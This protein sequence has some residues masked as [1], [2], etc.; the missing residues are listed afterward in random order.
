LKEEEKEWES[1]LKKDIHG[2]FAQVSSALK[3]LGTD[4]TKAKSECN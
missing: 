1:N 2:I 4:L 3:G